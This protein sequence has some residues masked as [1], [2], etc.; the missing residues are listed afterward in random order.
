LKDQFIFIKFK[1]LVAE[2]QEQKQ[3]DGKQLPLFAFKN[4]LLKQRK[5]Q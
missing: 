2:N 5:P 3:T 4:Q 1:E